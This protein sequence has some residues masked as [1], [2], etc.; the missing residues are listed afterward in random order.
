MHKS[1]NMAIFFVGV[2]LVL[3][4]VSGPFFLGNAKA[5]S[6]SQDPYSNEP[7]LADSYEGDSYGQDRYGQ[8][9]YAQP[10]YPSHDEYSY[11]STYPPVEPPV[12]PLEPTEC[13]ITGLLVY[14]VDNCPQKPKECSDGYLVF[15]TDNC[16]IHEEPP[17]TPP[18]I[19]D[20]ATEDPATEDPA[21]EDPATEDP[22]TEDPATE[23]PAAEDPATEEI[24]DDGIDN[25]GDGLVDSADPDDC[26]IPEVI[27]NNAEVNSNFSPKVSFIPSSIPTM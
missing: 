17:L 24:C 22:A 25:D 14:D 10:S 23:D 16:R 19:E 15:D 7:Y 11:G 4:I 12:M 6:Y 27:S 13:P 5:E 26:G 2:L 8:D 20:P 9:S 18:L 1:E 21:T 3:T